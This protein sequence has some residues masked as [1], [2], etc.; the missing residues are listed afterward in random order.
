MAI[1]ANRLDSIIDSIG[2]IPLSIST[3]LVH[4]LLPLIR[5]GSLLEIGN[6][7][8]SEKSDNP[9]GQVRM[10]LISN[11][12]KAAQS[13]RIPSRCAAVACLILLLKHLKVSCC[14]P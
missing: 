1:R 12:C 10:R 2:L 14:I 8:D 9:F 7:V 11:L 13:P 3:A 6:D 4:A 5:A